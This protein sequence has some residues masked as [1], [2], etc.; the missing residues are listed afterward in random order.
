MRWVLWVIGCAVAL[1]QLIICI[2][3][4]TEN[5]GASAVF[6][7]NNLLDSPDKVQYFVIWMSVLNIILILIAFVDI[8]TDAK[9]EFYQVVVVVL[10]GTGL[11]L[12]GWGI[13]TVYNLNDGILHMVGFICFITGSFVYLILINVQIEYSI[14]TIIMFI[15]LA[16][17]AGGYI[18][19]YL[20]GAYAGVDGIWVFVKNIEWIAVWL[21]AL[22]H[23]TI[24]AHRWYKSTH[25][26]KIHDYTVVTD[27][28]SGSVRR[29]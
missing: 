4:Y 15:I 7:S 25:D 3:A 22:E 2:I 26:N 1:T 18:V 13:L 19:T 20:I 10:F 14:Y 11:A 5:A 8:V 29:V 16:L 12:I 21:G 24:F 17:A 23:F 6:V 9:T 28:T 27:E